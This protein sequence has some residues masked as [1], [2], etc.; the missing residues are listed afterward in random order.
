MI[1]LWADQILSVPVAGAS[2]LNRSFLG[3]S[4]LSALD[5]R[6]QRFTLI[7]TIVGIDIMPTVRDS[8]EG[9]Q[10]VSIGIAV[11]SE[12]TAAT[13]SPD[14]SVEDEHPLRPWVWR[15]Q[16]RVFA[17]AVDDQNVVRV[18]ADV[19]LHSQRKLENGRPALLIRNV[20][21]QGTSTPISVTGLIRM[22]YL[23]S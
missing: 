1:T 16:F 3:L 20:D 18:R 10:L 11:V 6:I 23:I 14:P 5:R 4:A 15:A 9:D 2:A 13:G 17:S 21:N 7:R 8:G 12:E 19:D 22:L